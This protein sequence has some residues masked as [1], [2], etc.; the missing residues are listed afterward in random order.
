MLKKKPLD[1]GGALNLIKRKISKKF[2]LIN[3]DTYLEPNIQYINNKI[4]LKN[5]IGLMNVIKSNNRNIKLS[6]LKI[7]KNKIK[8]IED[9]AHG[10]SGEFKGKKLGTFGELGFSSPR[11]ILN[12]LTGGIL[13][14]RSKIYYISLPRYKLTNFDHLRFYLLNPK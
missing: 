12:I 2:F 13:Y 8:L 5:K 1:T 7:I 6:N 4:S 3:G 9:N 10:Y 14:F 11:K